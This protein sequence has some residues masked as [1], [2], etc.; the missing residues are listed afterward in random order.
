MKVT[1][2]AVK[3]RMATSVIV[4]AL[5]VLGVYGLWRLP[6][7]FVPNITYPL[8]R[9]YISWP[10]ATPEEIDKDLADPIER[11]LAAVD[12]LDYLESSSIEGLY[13]ALVNF[14]YGVD[15]NVAYQDCLAARWRG[16]PRVSPRT[17]KRRS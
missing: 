16:L 9:L 4:I 6:V 12:G 10:G 11:Q 13:T 8:I 17:S 14:K 5:V 1:E 2:S 3:R 15:V 7:N